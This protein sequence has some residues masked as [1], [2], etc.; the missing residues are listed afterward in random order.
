MAVDAKQI[1]SLAKKNAVTI[2]AVVV[3]AGAVAVPFVVASPWRTQAE[4]QMNERAGAARNLDAISTK[5]R[6][7]PHVDPD[8][9]PGTLERFPTKAVIEAGD[10]AVKALGAQSKEVQKAVL[11]VNRYRPLVPNAFSR[12]VREF[13]EALPRFREEYAKVMPAGLNALV[14]GTLPPTAEEIALRVSARKNQIVAERAVRQGQTILNQ[15]EI[16]QLQARAEVEEPAAFRNELALAH[17][18]YVSPTTW[19]PF[20]GIDAGGAPPRADALWLAQVGLWIQEDVA[21]IVAAANKG[22]ASIFASP[23]KHLVKVEVPQWPYMLQSQSGGEGGGSSVPV[24]K[25]D[26]SAEIK[27]NKS[28]NLTGR[29]SNG[30]YDVVHYRMTVR[31]TESAVTPFLAS[32]P[33]GRLHYVLRVVELRAIDSASEAV[34]GFVYGNDPVVELT[35]EVEALFLRSWTEALMPVPI[36]QRVGIDEPAVVAPPQ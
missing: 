30:L 21:S 9:E 27:L 8:A 14:K 16:A 22:S 32:I 12:R 13:N 2:V 23:V 20:P 5:S 31:L 26:P 4:E 10:A 17:Q 34:M 3:A 11:E 24:T 18:C 33:N 7:L 6:K 25:V 35:I 36:R 1:V 15:Q 28:M 29:Q 19:S